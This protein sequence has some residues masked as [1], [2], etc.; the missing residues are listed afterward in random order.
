[1][2]RRKKERIIISVFILI[3]LLLFGLVIAFNK[4]REKTYNMAENQVTSQVTEKNTYKE[5]SEDTAKRVSFVGVGDNLIHD[6]IYN[7]ADMRKG[8][9]GDGQYDFDKL[10]ENI[11][12]SLDKYDLRYINQ[13]SI[14]AGDQYGKSNYPL[15]NTPQAI[16]PSIEKA[17]FNI[18]NMA[19]N[20]S[21]DRG[22]Q[23]LV[24]SIKLWDK[25]G[26]CHIGAYESEE[27]RR[28]PV[29][30]EKKGIK[31]G[32]IAYTYGTNG[33]SPDTP[34]RIG[35]LNE[36]DIRSDIARLRR[37]GVDFILASAH[38]GQE[39]QLAIDS[40][41]MRYAQLFNDLGVDVVLGTH[42]HRIQKVEWKTNDKGKKTLIYYGTGNFV[43]NMIGAHTYLEGMAS[44]DFVKKGNDKYIDNPKFIPLVCHLE[45]NQYGYDGSVYRLD[46]YP[47]EL[48]N[49]HL[50]MRG[51]GAYNIE[52]YKNSVNSIVPKEFLE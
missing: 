25:T 36:K 41:Q 44:F 35:Y 12:P 39:G 13:E 43:A 28:K 42:A 51:A 5:K 47:V 15:F 45:A 29:I 3:S 24:D 32:L 40:V 14:V 9:Y 17:G 7:A 52:L 30:I 16:I 10:Y 49:R 8:V 1:M 19:N 38:W 50:Y 34:Y 20:H 48:A 33:M 22:S 27:S 23:G 31:I 2:R 4:V 26:L 18:I 37:A 46:E 21:L 11:K 6:S